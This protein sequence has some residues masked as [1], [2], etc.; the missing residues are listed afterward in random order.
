M[1]AN[2]KGLGGIKGLLLLHGEKIAMAL[3]AL[4][5]LWFIYSSL[6]LPEMAPGQATNLQQ[7]ITQ[8]NSKVEQSQWPESPDSPGWEDVRRAEP[9]VK[10]GGINVDPDHYA[11]SREGYNRPVVA[12]TVYRTD[13]LLLNVF[14]PRAT[15]GSGPLAFIDE[16]VRRK[17]QLE[18]AE[19]QQEAERKAREEAERM[20]R[21]Q[22][23]GQGYGGEGGRGY[24]GGRGEEGGYGDM[25]MV[26]PDHP[27][28][29]MI[30]GLTRQAGVPLQGDE[31]VEQAYWA[32]VVA[33]VPIREQKKLY[34]DAFRDA[35][36][37]FD[38]VR[39]FPRYV[40]YLV[41]RSEVV[42]GKPLEWKS[43]P[44]YDGQRK[45]LLSK[46]LAPNVNIYSMPKL[47]Q[48]AAQNWAG[49]ITDVVD[50]RYLDF[51]LTFPLPP[52]AG[53]DW[54]EEATHRDIPLAV[55]TPALEME[56]EP[57]PE[58]VPG[59]TP[60]DLGSFSST[61]DPSQQFGIGQGG[62]EGMR[63]GYGGDRGMMG[64]Y[65]GGYGGGEEGYGRRGGG[66]YGGRG[67]YGM[68]GY[69]RG[70]YGMGGYSRGGYGDEGGRGGYGG[71]GVSRSTAQQT[72]VVKGVDF[73]LL[74][75]IDFSVEPG[76]KYKYRVKLALAD[77]N[78]GLPDY[79]LAPA[80][81]DRQSKE[82]KEVLAKATDPKKATRPN[83][84]V[85]EEW[86]EPT[87][88]VGIPLTG[89]V[90]LA[91]TKLPANENY[92]DEPTAKLLI[93]SFDIDASGS[94]IQAAEL[95]DLRRGYVANMVTRDQK[96][97]GP[98]GRWIDVLDSFKFHTGITVLDM[99]GGEPL[100]GKDN[101][102]PSRVLLMGPAGQLYIRNEL[103]DKPAAD[104]HEY[105]M[106][107]YDKAIRGEST[108]PGRGGY[109]EEGGMRGGY[110]GY[111]GRGN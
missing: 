68:G 110:G 92:N 56:V 60:E 13:P 39:D 85:V 24:G 75:F 31:R 102:A 94:A 53:R 84:R 64:G 33:K 90:K 30:E 72:D 27:K 29:R 59:Q 4:L 69:G 63:G 107:Q 91:G 70:G 9:M 106:D 100:P 55:D 95:K 28:R 111:G 54:G 109:G 93:E 7:Q 97:L 1:K 41:E 73:W 82:W 78:A 16:A 25:A 40:G 38:P 76:K 105:L 79:V 87:P 80:V 66:E 104:L 89:S 44:V 46:P 108:Y 14:E 99:D 10:E 50:E 61:G 43:V 77:P 67:G 42:R 6:S 20:Q 17:R 18:E 101:T 8:T 71:G 103:E 19:K 37:G 65:R 2:L 74:R 12:P 83:H 36:G 5:A 49:Q 48:V 47:Y 81:Q 15:G 34:E 62:Y 32:M 35:K 58:Q 52:L 11:I 21:E 26:D 22:Q 98:D 57:L 96:Y 45:S 86:S 88:T 23:D 51:I 3:V